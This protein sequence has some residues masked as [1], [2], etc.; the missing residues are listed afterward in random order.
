MILMVMTTTVTARTNEATVVAR[1]D[2]ELLT[3]EHADFMKL[4]VTHPVL[5]LRINEILANRNEELILKESLVDNIGL[6]GKGL[7]VSIKGDPVFAG[8]KI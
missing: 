6:K 2:T 5:A 7:H 1:E 4:M 3:I 8:I